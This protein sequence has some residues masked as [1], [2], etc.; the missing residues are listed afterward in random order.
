MVSIQDNVPFPYRLRKEERLEKFIPLVVAA[1]PEIAAVSARFL[2]GVIARFAPHIARIAGNIG[3]RIIGSSLGPALG[4]EASAGIQAAVPRAASAITSALPKVAK[5]T[6]NNAGKLRLAGAYMDLT[7]D[8]GNSE[9]SF[10]RQNS[11]KK[12][13]KKSEDVMPY[14]ITKVVRAQVIPKVELDEMG[15]GDFS[16]VFYEKRK[17]GKLKKIEKSSKD[18]SILEFYELISKAGDEGMGAALIPGEFAGGIR[19][20][21]GGNDIF[22]PLHAFQQSP[23]GLNPDGTQRTRSQYAADVASGKEKITLEDNLARVMHRTI[24][25]GI[26]RVG[27][28]IKDHIT[29]P[30]GPPGTP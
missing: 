2:P 27:R 6:A 14:D 15:G 16:V 3:G 23:Y 11:S 25:A 22:S 18:I 20:N 8:S 13:L 12:S 10:R 19:G 21:H 17:N 4:A 30:K 9:K 24:P 29:G 26:K 7:G 5:L 28:R 1:A